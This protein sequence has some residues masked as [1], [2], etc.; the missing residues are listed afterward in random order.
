MD[1]TSRNVQVLQALSHS[2][3]K[4]STCIAKLENWKHIK[5]KG[6]K[7]QDHQSAMHHILYYFQCGSCD[8]DCVGYLAIN[9]G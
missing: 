5:T 9:R 6:A 3:K 2:L 1:S 4:L 7:T 8:M